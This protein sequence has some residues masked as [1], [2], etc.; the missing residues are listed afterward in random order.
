MTKAACYRAMQLGEEAQVINLVTQVFR[1]HVAPL[2]SDEGIAEFLRYAEENALRQRAERNHFTLVATASHRLIGAIEVRD[3][4]HISLLFV[5][6]AW[7]R[8]GIARELCNRALTIC[9]E[10]RPELQRLDVNASPNAVPA[11][12]RLGFRRQGPEQIKNGIRFLR[13]A[14]D[15]SE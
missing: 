14:L 7:Q 9:R 5:D 2:Y 8:R 4:S 15:L 1:E 13:M 11:Y 12:E 3:H 6:T 10:R